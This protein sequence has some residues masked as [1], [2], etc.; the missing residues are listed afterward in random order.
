MDPGLQICLTVT[1]Q[2]APLPL[3]ALVFNQQVQ[4][5]FFSGKPSSL[6]GSPRQQDTLRGAKVRCTFSLFV[7]RGFYLPS[8]LYSIPLHHVSSSSAMSMARKTPSMSFIT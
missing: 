8:F 1:P 4:R 7:W 2:S 5:T 3:G 6:E